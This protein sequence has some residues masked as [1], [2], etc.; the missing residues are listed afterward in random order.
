MAR[1]WS[2]TNQDPDQFEFVAMEYWDSY[3]DAI[4][5]ATARGIIVVEAAGNGGMDLDSSI[6]GGKFDRSVRDS[7]AILV[8]EPLVFVNPG[9]F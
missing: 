2:E 5:N 4:K 3:F 9:E 8:G 1:P 7:G 6:Y